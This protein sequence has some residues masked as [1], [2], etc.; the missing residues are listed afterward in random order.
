MDHCDAK[1]CSHKCAYDYELEDYRCTCPPKL[2]LSDDDRTC[3]RALTDASTEAPVTQPSIVVELLPTD[4]LWSEWS[5]WSPCSATCGDSAVRSRNRK[6]IIPARNG[7][8]CRGKDLESWD[9]PPKPC[10][11]ITTTTTTETIEVSDNESGIKFTSTEI[12]TT[13]VKQSTRDEPREFPIFSTDT[14]TETTI[15]DDIERVT[16]LQTTTT[17]QTEIE[18]TTLI[19]ELA[20]ITTIK[21]MIEVPEVAVEETI[22]DEE[23]EFGTK[24]TTEPSEPL[25]TTLSAEPRVIPEETTETIKELDGTQQTTMRSIEINT[26]TL[27]PEVTTILDEEIEPKDVGKTTTI[28]TGFFPDSNVDQTTIAAPIDVTTIS[29]DELTQSADETEVIIETTTI[30]ILVT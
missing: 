13:T 24:I 7:G 23:R 4:C 20:E 10:E 19:K 12:P 17:I 16:E 6:V 11:S 1:G 9:C 18:T 5:D 27:K 14:T 26:T 2:Y 30:T 21:P 28:R 22:R 15:P 25:T 8:S 29:P 3:R